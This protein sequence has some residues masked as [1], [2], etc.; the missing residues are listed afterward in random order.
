MKGRSQ[1]SHAALFR[2][3]V[4]ASGLLGITVVLKLLSPA[5][6]GTD[7][8]RRILGVLMG[9]V[10]VIYANAVPK[11]LSPLLQLRCDPA[12]EQALRRFTGWSLVLGG[13]AYALAWAI[14]PLTYANILAAALLGT[15]VL[16][17][18]FRLALA[19]KR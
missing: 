12:V 16:L 5:H 13:A 17:V 8:A 1:T 9:A 7:T 2:G 4:V 3:L 14:A 19:I 11:T 6:L 10:V 18:V 15:A